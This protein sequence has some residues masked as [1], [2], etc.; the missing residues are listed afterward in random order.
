[1]GDPNGEG[2]E[3]FP[4]YFKSFIIVDGN[5]ST[6]LDVKDPALILWKMFLCGFG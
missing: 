6:G 5:V 3:I 2:G 1:M 4:C